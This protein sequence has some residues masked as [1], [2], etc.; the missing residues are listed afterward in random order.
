[1][2]KKS[3]PELEFS[4]EFHEKEKVEDGQRRSLSLSH[5]S[6]N[7]SDPLEGKKMMMGRKTL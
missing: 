5:S 6:E 4:Q 7:L 1:M 2:K 3:P